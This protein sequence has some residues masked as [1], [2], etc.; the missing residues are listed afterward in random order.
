MKAERLLSILTILMSGKRI[1]AAKLAK[2]LEV[3][4]RTVYR[5][6]EAL[7]L[8]GFP[9]YAT[10]GRDGGFGLIEGFRMTGQIFATGEIQKI[11]SAL[12]G[13][14]GIC[15]ASEVEALRRKF[16]LL[17]EESN[18]RGVSCPENRIYIEL[19]PSRRE[20][21]MTDAL[22]ES[23]GR[24]TA[25][26]MK[27]CD[28]EGKETIR[29]IEPLALVFYWQSWFVYSWCR[30]RKA[31]RCF[32]IARICSLEAIESKREGPPID[33]SERPW[34][35]EWEGDQIEKIAFAADASTRG[36]I[37]EYFEEDSISVMEDGRLLVKAVFPTGDWV[38]SWIMGLPGTVSILYPEHLKEKIRSRAAELADKNR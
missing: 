37:A 34:M 12:D 14:S 27:Y 21:K 26:R 33:L 28:V 9:V 3:S 19:T 35:K 22:D 17:L 36:R 8:A 32:R 2:D 1:S 7:S 4:A 30:L 23:I 18:T 11:I 16:A 13:L 6:V 5:D 24:R 31:H 29:E 25:L 15:P 10:T 20:K 38:A